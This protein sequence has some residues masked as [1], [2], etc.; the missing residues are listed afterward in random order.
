MEEEAVNHTGSCRS[1]LPWSRWRVEG[2]IGWIF[3]S[4]SWLLTANKC[5]AKAPVNQPA[6]LVFGKKRRNQL[7]SAT[8]LQMKCTR[9]TWDFQDLASFRYLQALAMACSNNKLPTQQT[10][11][12]WVCLHSISDV[13]FR[14][15]KKKIAFNFTE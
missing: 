13:T 1:F 5:T 10:L 11:Y 6:Q 9:K 3:I 12:R 4:I 14:E 2:G 15:F 7:G 8:E